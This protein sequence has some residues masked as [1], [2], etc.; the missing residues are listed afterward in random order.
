MVQA[1]NIVYLGEYENI[2]AYD[3]NTKDIQKEFKVEVDYKV[4]QIVC[5]HK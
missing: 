3:L 5:L 2:Q 4:H 1:G